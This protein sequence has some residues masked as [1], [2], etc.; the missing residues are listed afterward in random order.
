MATFGQVKEAVL[1]L[2]DDEEGETYNEDLVL[3]A[4]GVALDE[5][6]PWIPKLATTTLASGSS[7]FTLPSDLYAVEAVL[8]AD[9]E[10]LPRVR[11]LVG[12]NFSD[13][14]SPNG[15]MFFPSGSITFGIPLTEAYT[16]YYL[17]QWAKPTDTTT[18]TEAL[19]PPD[20]AIYPI[21]LY[22][23]AYCIIRDAVSIT[24]IR[25]FNTRVDGGNPEDNPR[26][27]AILFLIKMF[28]DTISRVPK[29]QRVG[30]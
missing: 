24:E 18:D 9:G 29:Y 26:Q 30:E 6:L 4:I 17:A 23:A 14:I 8:D 20:Y 1:R 19:E 15:Y 13:N 10:V 16:L 28:K 22:A 11:L 3:D 12:D 2:L 5:I 21:T 27:M 25:Q 7:T